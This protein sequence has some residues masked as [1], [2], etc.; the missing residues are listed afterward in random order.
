[1]IFIDLDKTLMHTK[2][3]Q[4]VS[5]PVSYK[6]KEPNSYMSEEN[7]KKIMSII[8]NTTVIPITS[9]TLNSY[10]DVCF[11]DSCSYALV[12]NGA[13]LLKNGVVDKEWL[14]ESEFLLKEYI[15]DIREIRLMMYQ[16]GYVEKWGSPFVLDFIALNTLNVDISVIER[17]K[18]K[19]NNTFSIHSNSHKSM[20]CVPKVLDKGEAVKRFIEYIGV[21][22]SIYIAGDSSPDFSMLSLPFETIGPQN[23]GAKYKYMEDINKN[24]YAFTDFVL[25]ILSEKNEV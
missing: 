1:M 3:T 25:N 13:V 24:P 11:S 23:S 22:E 17:V 2:A 12:E 19:F 18:N 16:A 7:Y 8:N 14:N 6:F 4:D 10:Y 5:Y 15:S 9:R 21:D 20:F